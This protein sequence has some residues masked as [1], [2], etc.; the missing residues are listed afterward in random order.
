MKALSVKDVVRILSETEDKQHTEDSI[1]KMFQRNSL[2]KGIK[3]LKVGWQII[4]MVK[5][6]DE[7]KDK[8]L[9]KYKRQ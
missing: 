2:P 6:E 8:F 9:P 5:S 1:R 3:A 7:I 4:F